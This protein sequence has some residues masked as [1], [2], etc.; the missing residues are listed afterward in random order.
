MCLQPGRLTVSWAAS[1]EGGPARQGRG[2]F[3]LYFS[4]T[5]PHLEYSVQV[6][7]LQHRKDEEVLEQ[8]E[9]RP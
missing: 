3:P 6:S 9:R 1:K 5:R 2:L 4:L 8:V 7:V